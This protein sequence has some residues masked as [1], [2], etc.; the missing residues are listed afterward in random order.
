MKTINFKNR[1]NVAKTILFSFAF[2]T[3]VS[4]FASCTADELPTKTL[5]KQQ[6]ISA[7]DGEIVPPPPPIP[8]PKP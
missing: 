1:K 5:T 2:A 7:K 8:N 3:L 6:T 4:L